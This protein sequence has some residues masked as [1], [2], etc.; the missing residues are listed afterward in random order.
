VYEIVI[1]R[2][3]LN[4]AKKMGEA[5]PSDNAVLEQELY[6]MI[7]DYTTGSIVGI[8]IRLKNDQFVFYNR[9][10]GTWQGLP[11]FANTLYQIGNNQ[12]LIDLC[13]LT[14]EN[15]SITPGFTPYVF[16]ITKTYLLHMAYPLIDLYTH[17]E[18]G[19]VVVTFNTKILRS[20]VNSPELSAQKTLQAYNIL[21]GEDGF[22]I[23]HPDTSLIGKTL[24]LEPEPEEG[25][26]EDTV[27]LS[28]DWLVQHED[29]GRLGLQLYSLTDKRII[30]NQARSYTYSLLLVLALIVVAQL[31]VLIFMMRRM[32]S[33]VRALQQGLETVQNG[34]LDVCVK[35]VG[36]HEVAR[37]IVAFNSMTQRLKQSEEVARRHSER[38]IAAMERQRIAEVKTLE[39][40]INSHFLYN[41]LNSI[42]YTA[43]RNGNLAV[44]QQIKHLAHVL[45]YTFEKSDGVVTV[46]TE[47][48]W[49]Q[50][51]LALQKLRFGNTFDYTITVDPA[52]KSWTMRKLIIQPF[53]ENSVLHGFEGHTYGCFISVHFKPF[54]EDRMCVEI[55]DNGNGMPPERLAAVRAYIRSQHYEPSVNG[56]GLE[57][58]FQRIHSYYHKKARIYLRSWENIGTTV[59]LLLP[60]YDADEGKPAAPGPQA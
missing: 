19:V 44:S 41:T 43:I 32:M 49:L 31:A 23:A 55:R 60:P 37:S 58:A 40:Q 11:W 45:R 54:R 25:G 56:I 8:T 35:P 59:V 50:E 15:M 21:T 52:V 24:S 10:Y 20:L 9:L 38:T 12:A 3:I 33:S 14:I 42:S 39:N 17:K 26:Q 48:Q 47:A 29:V 4:E 2:D 27:Y 5:E 16:P 51:Y 1:D 34:Q 53:V 7:K 22:I 18:Y 28:G 6:Q 30:S 57:N 13:N 46:V 36:K